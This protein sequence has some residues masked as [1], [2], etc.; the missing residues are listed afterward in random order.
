MENDVKE[1]TMFRRE[2]QN[3]ASNK[4]KHIPFSLLVL[5][6]IICHKYFL[7]GFL[8]SDSMMLF[9]AQERKSK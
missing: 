7:S 1:G 6:H 9:Y 8:F 3:K 4:L 5:Y 2:K